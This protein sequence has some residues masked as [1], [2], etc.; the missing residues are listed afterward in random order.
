M[1]K[2]GLGA[3][4]LCALILATVTDG[5][6]SGDV[7]F[8]LGN[9]EVD[10]DFEPVEEQESFGVGVILHNATWPVSLWIGVQASDED[11][12]VFDPF[13]GSFTFEAEISELYFGVGKVWD[14]HPKARPYISGGLTFLTVDAKLTDPFGLSV[15][16]DDSTIAP[17]VEGGI[18]WRIGKSFNIGIGARLV[19]MAEVDFFGVESDADYTQFNGLIGW[20]W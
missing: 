12:A 9:R 8:V 18:F 20:G 11:A 1:R 17:Y 16:A 13:L 5:Y 10:E 14:T 3:M 4:I 19:I 6:C 15:D 7:L 2:V